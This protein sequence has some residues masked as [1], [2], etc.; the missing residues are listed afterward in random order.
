M[1]RLLLFDGETGSE[2]DFSGTARSGPLAGKQLEKVRALKEYWFDW[3]T[4]N[5]QTGLYTAGADE[6]SGPS[7]MPSPTATP[8]S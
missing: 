5:P 1:R 8:A 2:W 3:K 4:Y 6:A 7:P